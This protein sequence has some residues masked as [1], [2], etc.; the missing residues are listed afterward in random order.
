MYQLQGHGDSNV[1][2][3]AFTADKKFVAT[4]AL[5]GTVQFWDAVTGK[6]WLKLYLQVEGVIHELRL[7]ND[8]KSLAALSRET[9]EIQIYDFDMHRVPP[10]PE[11]R[12]QIDQLLTRLTDNDAQTRDQ[13]MHDLAKLG[14]VAEP[15]L[16]KASA[17]ADVEVG[18]RARLAYKEMCSPN[19]GWC[20]RALPRPF[21]T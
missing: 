8:Q 19:R 9:H 17:S 12:Q 21:T 4:G 16:R 6:E 7:A 3:V 11:Q 20:S 18:M 15:D 10:S 5:D 1:L 14:P 2:G 13:A